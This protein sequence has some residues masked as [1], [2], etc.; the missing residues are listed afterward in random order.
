MPID[1]DMPLTIK[2]HQVVAAESP[3]GGGQG[4]VIDWNNGTLHGGSDPR[5]DGH[6]AGY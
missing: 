6:A 5:K 1:F 2:G 3:W 4:I